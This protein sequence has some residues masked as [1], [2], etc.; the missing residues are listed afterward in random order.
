MRRLFSLLPLVLLP[1]LAGLDTVHA[2]GAAAVRGDLAQRLK[3]RLAKARIGKDRYGVVV[4]SREAR[5]RVHFTSGASRPLLPASAAKLLTAASVLDHLGPGHVFRTLVSARGSLSQDGVL[6]GDLVLHGSGDPNVSGRFHDGKP[7][8]VPASLARQVFD[9]GIRRV[10][11]DLVLDEGPFDTE[12]VHADWSAADKRRWYGAPVGGLSFNDGCIDV[13]AT[14]G[15]SGSRPA[16]VF[17]ATTGPWRVKN[18]LKTVTGARA[19]VGGRWIDGGRTLEVHGRL[20]PRGRA[21]M[22]V[23]VPDPSRFLGG[24]MLQAL[25]GAGVRVDGNARRPQEPGGR[26]PGKVVAL[27]ESELPPA[28]GVMNTRS[29]NVYASLLF[30]LAGAQV[31]G[32]AT[33]ESGN[34]AV[35][36]MLARRRIAD[37]GTTLMRDG[38]GLSLQNRVS[39]GVL[40][41]VLHAFDRDPLR[42]PLMHESLAVAG[43]S[44]TLARRLRERGVKGRVRGKTG[45][46]NDQRARALAGYVEGRGG[47]P[48]LVFAI[49]LNGRG[50]S[51]AVID[52]LVREICR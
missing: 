43:T 23:P 47:K 27:H 46:L 10:T 14:A 51:H 22:H 29:Q 16:L 6:N 30:K 12:F 41:Q 11:G 7:M 13:T 31:T 50:A 8:T 35:R 26:R 20:P 19:A 32:E 1:L 24:A 28:L 15:K 25:R 39:A 2:R 36:A 49:L 4:M 34:E 3:A 5:P 21:S 48:G 42:G 38:S 44:G 40:A 45:T 18:S 33:W 17:P 9:A 37:G 52:D